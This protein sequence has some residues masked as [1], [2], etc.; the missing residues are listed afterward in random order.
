MRA[1][2]TYLIIS[3]ICFSCKI[4][5]GKTDN[6][7]QI[8]TISK[9][10]EL[11]NSIMN[12]KIEF[13]DFVHD[14]KPIKYP[15][16]IGDSI[17][18][19]STIVEMRG[20]EKIN[21]DIVDKY[22]DFEYEKKDAIDFHELIRFYKVGQISIDSNI[23]GLIYLKSYKSRY[24]DGGK[25][26]IY[27]IVTFDSNGNLISQKDIAGFITDLS[28]GDDRSF[29]NRCSIDKD[30]K[31]NLMT[32]EQVADYDLDSLYIISETEKNYFI[33]KQGEIK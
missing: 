27:K 11:D 28:K 17:L 15:F 29:W 4:N 25:K 3:L 16:V 2:Q 24:I 5:S 32:K 22:L 23:F 33:D 20:L 13:L 30:L 26:D 31:I 1:I 21:F 19:K 7:E 8:D 9:T 12:N 6:S 14:F 18:W 10:Q